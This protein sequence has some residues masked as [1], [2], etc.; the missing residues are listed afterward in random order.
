LKGKAFASMV[1]YGFILDTE[2]GRFVL[3]RNSITLLVKPIEIVSGYSFEISKVT[4]SQQQNR[5][6]KGFLKDRVIRRILDEA[7]AL[8]KGD[9]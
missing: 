5:I 7:A 4:A 3:T 9:K 6:I 1:S 2:M 8:L